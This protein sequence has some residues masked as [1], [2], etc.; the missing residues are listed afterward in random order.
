MLILGKCTIDTYVSVSIHNVTFNCYTPC[1]YKKQD[2]R[3]PNAERQLIQCL[4]VLPI[5]VVLLPLSSVALLIVLVTLVSTTSVPFVSMLGH[6][7]VQVQ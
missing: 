4:H 7:S 2:A 1:I 5:V 3:L 6:M